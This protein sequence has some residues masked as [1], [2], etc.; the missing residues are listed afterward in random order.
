MQYVKYISTYLC[1]TYCVDTTFMSTNNSGNNNNNT[2]QAY[3]TT[4]LLYGIYIHIEISKY[5]HIV[6]YIHQ[7]ILHISIYISIITCISVPRS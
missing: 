1:K 4:V 2:K 3:T 7:H 6:S 5:I